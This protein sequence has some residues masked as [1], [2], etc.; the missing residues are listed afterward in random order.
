MRL[1]TA[2][3][4]AAWLMI[5]ALLFAP[6]PYIWLVFGA[7]AGILGSMFYLRRRRRRSQVE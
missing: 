6:S 3:R 5:P 4:I 1:E 7:Q 2:L